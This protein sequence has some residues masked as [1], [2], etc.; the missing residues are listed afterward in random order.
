MP[1]TLRAARPVLFT[2]S[3]GKVA[4]SHGAQQGQKSDIK[5]SRYALRRGQRAEVVFR[6]LS[7][8]PACVHRRGVAASVGPPDPDLDP[9]LSMIGHRVSMYPW[10]TGRLPIFVTPLTLSCRT[11]STSPP[12][13]PWSDA[14]SVGR[15]DKW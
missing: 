6:T 13:R 3:L 11:P 10:S 4:Q 7:S 12:L 8:R 14:R 15:A 2:S 1:T 5:R 9:D